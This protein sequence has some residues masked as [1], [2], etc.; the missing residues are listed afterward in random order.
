MPESVVS[1][2]AASNKFIPYEDE[3]KIKRLDALQRARI[4]ALHTAYAQAQ[5]DAAKRDRDQAAIKPDVLPLLI[6]LH[7]IFPPLDDQGRPT[8]EP[9]PFAAALQSDRSPAAVKKAYLRATIR[10]H[11]VRVTPAIFRWL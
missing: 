9:Y 10:V 11:P 3:V 6:N 8:N 1:T 5:A 2:T 7:T 4:G